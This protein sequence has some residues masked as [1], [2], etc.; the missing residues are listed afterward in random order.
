VVAVVVVAVPWV[1]ESK[2]FRDA[3][4]A[5]IAK[6]TGR[7]LAIDGDWNLR[8]GLQPRITA[9]DVRFGN[10]DWAAGPNMAEVR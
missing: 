1:L 7:E 4:V 3:V 6:E 5:R 9:R 10:A 8:L 2:L